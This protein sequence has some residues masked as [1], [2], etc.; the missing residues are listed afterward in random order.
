MSKIQYI[1]ILTLFITAFSRAQETSNNVSPA[2]AEEASDLV[3]YATGVGLT[4]VE[5]INLALENNLGLEL[6]EAAP[7]ISSLNIIKEKAEYDP[8]VNLEFKYR[9]ETKALG[10]SRPERFIF[11]SPSIETET[12]TYSGEIKQKLPTGGNISLLGLAQRLEASYAQ[13]REYN[14]EFSIGLEQPLLKNFGIKL[15]GARINYYKELNEAAKAD[16][17]RTTSD[18][19]YSVIM[20]YWEVTRAMLSLK[21]NEKALLAANE[22]Y[23][24]NRLKVEIGM[25]PSVRMLEAEAAVKAREESLLRAQT[26]L[27]N[28]IDELNS[29]IYGKMGVDKWNENLKPIDRPIFAKISVDLQDSLRTALEERAEIRSA[30]AIYNA[31]QLAEMVMRNQK[32][33]E[34]NIF[35]RT[36]PNASEDKPDDMWRTLD[37]FDYDFWEVGAN[38]KYYLGNRASNANYQQACLERQQAELNLDK[39]KQ[40]ITKQV[41]KAIR[42][43]ENNYKRVVATQLGRDVAER[44]LQIQKDYFESGMATTK[45]ILDYQSDLAAAELA[46]ISAIIDYM[47]SIAEIERVK[48]TLIYDSTFGFGGSNEEQT[49]N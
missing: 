5:C 9:I 13:G 21:V 19:V 35:G 12:A 39:A 48:G 38:F 18:L 28:V 47:L 14:G 7:Q 23:R 25:L 26:A 24:T 10:G 11:G 2:T 27:G 32:L 36:G 20:Y 34:F 8:Q 4:L 15:A 30:K 33:P 46:E 49:E 42:E 43:L 1:L 45:D 37:T 6:A 29:V 22:I 41:R 16:L 40:D 31:K 3:F 44:N 17:E